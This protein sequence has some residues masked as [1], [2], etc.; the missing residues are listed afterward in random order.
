MTP[1]CKIVCP[2]NLSCSLQCREAI[3]LVHIFSDAIGHIFTKVLS[4]GM[5]QL[6]FMINPSYPS[7]RWPSGYFIE[8]YNEPKIHCIPGERIIVV[9]LTFIVV[10]YLFIFKS[11]DRAHLHFIGH[12]FTQL[13]NRH[14]DLSIQRLITHFG[15]LNTF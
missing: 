4:G 6:P 12:I 8:Y 1:E 11:F 10:G 2:A 3:P 15:A 9:V 7:Q 14:F 5:Q 13:E